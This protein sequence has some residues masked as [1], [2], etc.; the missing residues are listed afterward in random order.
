M[1][2][3]DSDLKKLK[4][5][6]AEL[7]KEHGL[8]SFEFLNENFDIELIQSEGSELLIKRIRKQ[9]LDKISSGIRAVEMFINPQ[10]APIFIFNVIKSFNQTDKDI[11]NLLY[12]KFAEFEIEAFGLDSTYNEKKELEFIKRVCA[13]WPDICKDF[14]RIYNSMRIN[15]KK[16]SKKNEKSYLG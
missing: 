6:C 8:P 2:K 13:D 9:I 14:E 12:N 16:E 7:Q 11:L 1:E 10:N 4:E 3:P 15:Y 5:R